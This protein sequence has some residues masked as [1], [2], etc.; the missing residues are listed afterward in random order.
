M[1]LG[2]VDDLRAVCSGSLAV[3]V[4]VVN[5]EHQTLR[6]SSGSQPAQHRCGELGL[7]SEPLRNDHHHGVTK[8]DFAVLNRAALAIN[9]QADLKLNAAHSQSIMALAS[10]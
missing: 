6:F 9:F 10:R 1:H 2:F 5:I 8:S 7:N 3:R 4:N